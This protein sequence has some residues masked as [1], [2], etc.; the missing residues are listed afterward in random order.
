[1]NIV[2]DFFHELRR[3]KVF[4][5]AVFYIV[6]AW[7]ALQVADLA[8]PGLG[9]PEQAIRHVWIGAFVGFPLALIFAW[10][11]QVTKQGIVRTAPVGSGETT[12]LVLNRQDYLILGLLLLVVGGVT[13]QLVTE[14]RQIPVPAGLAPLARLG[15]RVF[16]GEDDAWRGPALYLWVLAVALGVTLVQRY[17]ARETSR[18][19]SA[20]ANRSRSANRSVTPRPVKGRWSAR[21]PGSS[22]RG[23]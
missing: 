3:R 16:E 13:Y 23:R 17:A 12:N 1:M 14:I 21:S 4:Q 15:R 11:Y 6:G 19:S 7:V 8:F 20:R 10:R 22:R 18:S 2:G 9:I 5:S